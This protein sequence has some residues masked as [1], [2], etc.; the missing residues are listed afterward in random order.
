MDR[1]SGWYKRKLQLITLVLALLLSVALNA[2]TLAYANSLRR[3]AALRTS[4]ITAA[5]G[6]VRQGL[7]VETD[8]RQLE[9]S[10]LEL[11]FPIGWST[12]EGDPRRVPADAQGW[13]VKVVGC[14]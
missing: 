9:R 3:D 1:V 8:I 7:P 6:A 4:V 11:Q 10:F 5:Q 13:L 12:E 14:W 2:D